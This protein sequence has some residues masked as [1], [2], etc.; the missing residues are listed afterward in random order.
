MSEPRYAHLTAP[1]R[2][3]SWRKRNKMLQQAAADALGVDL[4]SYN[5]WER[6]RER[7]GIDMCAHIQAVTRGY[8]RLGQW[9]Q[10]LALDARRTRAS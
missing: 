7:P 9:T 3:A 2:L 8:V 6:G 1:P 4:A 5:A 10:D